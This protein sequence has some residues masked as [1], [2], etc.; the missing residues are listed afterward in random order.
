MSHNCNFWQGICI[1]TANHSPSATFIVYSN[2][3]AL[4]PDEELE[5]E[6]RNSF[7]NFCNHLRVLVWL[8]NPDDETERITQRCHSWCWKASKLTRQGPEQ[9]QYSGF[10]EARWDLKN[11]SQNSQ[12]KGNTGTYTSAFRAELENAP[13]G[14]ESRQTMKHVWRQ[15][16]RPSDRSGFKER[17]I[18]KH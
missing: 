13:R 16:S 14:K 1:K 2:Y 10:L 11:M 5:C 8:R 3:A 6:R 4:F 17:N 12:K 9:F 18:H 7:K 15:R